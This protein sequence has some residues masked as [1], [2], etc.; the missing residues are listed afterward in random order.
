[1]DRRSSLLSLLIVICLSAGQAVG[2]LTNA[3]R[4]RLNELLQ[5]SDD[6]K[7][8]I[9]PGPALH[10][11]LYADGTQREFPTQ[12][13]T[14]PFCGSDLSQVD[15]ASL[16]EMADHHR[17]V[18]S[19]PAPVAPAGSQRAAMLNLV[20]IV[21]NAPPG[22]Q[23][24][25]DAVEAKLESIFTDNI[26]VTIT[27][28]FAVLDPNI[29]GST[30]SA[31]VFPVSY[32]TLRNGLVN[33]MDTDD[34]IQ[35]SLPTG[36]SIPVRYDGNTTVVTNET[37]LIVN[38]AT[39]NATIGFA[40]GNAASMTINSIF[41]WDFDPSNGV[42]SNMQDFQ[43]VLTHEVGHALGFTSGIGFGTG[44]MTILDIYRFQR[45]DGAGNFNPDTLAQ[46]GTTAR[47]VDFNTPDDDANS[48][49]ITSE[50]RM[51]DGTPFQA[52]HFR[53]QVP[54]IGN[55]DPAQANGESFFP[56]FYQP[57]DREMFDAIGWDISAI[58]DDATPPSPDPMQWEPGGEPA[59]TS[60]TEITMT[61]A[62]ATD[63]QN[64]SGSQNSVE[65][66]LMGVSG[67]GVGSLCW[68]ATRTF[69]D[70]GLSPNEVY[71]YEARARDTAVPPNETMP[72]MPA[73]S[74]TTFIES[75][76]TFFFGTVTDTSIGLTAFNPSG[77]FS[78]LAVG[79]SGLF[80][81]MT[82]PGGV[83]ANVWVQSQFVDVTGL[84][85]GTMYTV[86]VK[87]RNQ[88]GVET[89]FTFAQ[90]TTTTGSAGCALVGDVNQDGLVNGEDI[91]GY[92]RAKLGQPPALGE[93]PLCADFGNGGD[94][95]LDTA[96]FVSSL[97]A[98]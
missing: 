4:L 22:A 15:A 8:I 21:T 78:N 74:T 18:L 13:V 39:F 89:P 50:Y 48:D 16:R 45:T 61:A 66:C 24:A 35:T 10:T 27:I 2:Q 97:L 56:D 12:I 9:E 98:S 3:S 87:A 57:S 73:L 93:D 54:S 46:F 84:T 19:E 59:A 33:G 37:Q 34:F 69:T 80:F 71:S 20:F 30:G 26:T 75:P 72:S 77:A 47:L 81:E 95:T 23:A 65:Y 60:S 40:G 82:P 76:T 17:A 28:N 68:Q 6:T 42:P 51:A 14:R 52:S 79:N 38:V 11:T 55:M 36:S 1:M 64:P 92:L 58:P 83:N 49:T 91:D 96:A 86:R 94:L 67:P 41:P 44:F 70:T 53:Q 29:L 43:S 62:L 5:R 32:T 90:S 85:P 31:T 7:Q 25:I 88:L 63:P